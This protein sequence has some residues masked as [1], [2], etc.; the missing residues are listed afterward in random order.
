MDPQ[1]L[2][3]LNRIIYTIGIT[4]L[5]MFMNSTLG[6]MWGY[7]FIQDEWHWSN[8]LFY[9]FFILSLVGLIYFLIQLWKKP[10]KFDP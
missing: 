5:W 4:V 10:I 7:A 3:F 6:I 1:V 2:A 8:T 9:L